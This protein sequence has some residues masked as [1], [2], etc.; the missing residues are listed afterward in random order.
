MGRTVAAA[1]GDGVPCSAV[2]VLSSD[3]ASAIHIISIELEHPSSTVGTH[4]PWNDDD[5]VAVI[6]R[7]RF[8][9]LAEVDLI[10]GEGAPPPPP[11]Q[12][13][14][15]DSCTVDGEHDEGCPQFISSEQHTGKD[16]EALRGATVSVK[17]L[18]KRSR[19][20]S[21]L[22]KLAALASLRGF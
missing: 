6:G 17:S 9:K 4:T 13:E 1:D 5:L 22:L 2:V 16:M 15:V 11:S 20:E 18:I 21:K 8:P 7:S 19:A 10:M 14:C 12:L 3:E